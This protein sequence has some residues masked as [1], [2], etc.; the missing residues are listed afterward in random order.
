MMF[1]LLIG[2]IASGKSTWTARRAR[3]GAIVLNDDSLVTSLHGGHYEMYDKKLKPLYKTIPL[4]LAGMTI[5]AGRDVIID[6]TNL[7][8]AVRSRWIGMAKMYDVPVVGVVFDRKGPAEHA[9]R[10]TRSDDRGY[11]FDYWLKVA[12]YHD[13]IYE[14]PDASEGFDNLVPIELATEMLEEGVWSTKG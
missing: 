14:A 7:T 5:L 9:G 6:S 12:R 1:E 10:R 8:R 11:D 13:S 3:E 2:P 4:M